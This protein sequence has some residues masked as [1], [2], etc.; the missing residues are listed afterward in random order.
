MKQE[1]D[2]VNCQAYATIFS[3]YFHGFN[4]Q[5]FKNQEVPDKAGKNVTRKCDHRF[6]Y[7][8]EEA[9]K[10]GTQANEDIF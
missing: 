3:N 5:T 10:G 9:S 6:F 7:F 1:K 8:K 4:C 2:S